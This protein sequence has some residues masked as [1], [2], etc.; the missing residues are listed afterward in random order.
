MIRILTDNGTDNTN[1][2]DARFKNLSTGRQSGF[3]AGFLNEGSWAREQMAL[4]TQ[5]ET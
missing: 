5:M 1:I 3:T 4:H 2:D